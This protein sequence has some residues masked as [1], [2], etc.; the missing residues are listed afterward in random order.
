MALRSLLSTLKM[1]LGPAVAIAA[2]LVLAPLL[3]FSETTIK[4]ILDRWLSQC[5]VVLDARAESNGAVLVRIHTFGD[6]PKSLPITIVAKTGL[7]ERVS[8]LNHVEQGSAS[9]E[10]NLLVH[11][12]ANQRCPGALCE[13]QPVA[14]ERLTIRISPMSPNYLYQLRVLTSNSL[15]PEDINTYV[16]P[17]RDDQVTCRVERA[18]ASNFVA[19]QPRELQLLIFSI[20]FVVATLLVGLLRHKPQ[21]VQNE[22]P[23]RRKLRAS[24]RRY[25]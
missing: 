1:N 7:V 20:G 24:D 3:A 15:K 4:G 16:R 23:P 22:P 11:P 18:A 14:A 25:R 21:G 10:T 6:M 17:L 19:R 5:V 2:T 8:L 9:S 12:Q 13:E